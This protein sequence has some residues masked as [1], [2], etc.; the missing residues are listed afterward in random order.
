MGNILMNIGCSKVI[1]V[2]WGNTNHNNVKIDDNLKDSAKILDIK[3]SEQQFRSIEEK[4]KQEIAMTTTTVKVLDDKIKKILREG[5]GIYAKLNN[6]NKCEVMAYMQ[7]RK[8]T[9]I[10]LKHLITN[11]VNAFA[12]SNKIR[13]MRVNEQQSVVVD[14]ALKILNKHK[15]LDPKKQQKSVDKRSDTLNKLDDI[16]SVYQDETLEQISSINSDG[17]DMEMGLNSDELLESIKQIEDELSSEMVYELKQLPH[18]NTSFHSSRNYSAFHEYK[19]NNNNN[20]NSDLESNNIS[21]ANNNNTTNR[22]IFINDG[23]T[24][25]IKNVLNN[26]F[27]DGN[28]GLGI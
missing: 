15:V 23:I 3:Q 4:T 20:N 10:H 16:L 25:D 19:D 12:I 17:M 7:K 11:D 18:K 1:G 8:V 5:G 28:T 26:Q 13:S 14:A 21:N 24:T 6:S 2:L 9:E 22:R 27:R